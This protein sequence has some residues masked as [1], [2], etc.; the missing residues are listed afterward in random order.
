[1]LKILTIL[2]ARP[3]F[4]KAS[5]VSRV[6]AMHNDMQEILVHTGQHFDDNMSRVFFE[7]MQIPEPKYNLGIHSL[8]HGAM[9]GRM[10]EAAEKI[11]MEEKPDRVL[12]YGDTNST[13]AGALAAKKLGINIAHV[14]AGL[15]SFNMD[16]PEEVN[17]I[18]T[19]RISS[20]LFCPTIVAVNNLLDEGF[21][22]FSTEIIHSGD[23]MLDA[24]LYFARKSTPPQGIKLPSQFV[25]ATIHRAENTDNHEVFLSIAEAI[26]K[27]A[28]TVQVV[29]PMHP[30]T[31]A[32]L[33]NHMISF[34]GNVVIIPPVGYLEMIYLL[35]HCMAVITDSGGLQKEAY[36]FAK[37][38]VTTRNQ[39]EWTEL[40]EAGYNI[41]AGTR[42]DSIIKAFFEVT[43]RELV[44]T[45]GLY[46][47]GNA[48]EIIVENLRG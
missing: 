31:A 25:L 44:F 20:L 18:I 42:K 10:T 3:Q 48:A 28:Q 43:S 29:L 9:T 23:V 40:A 38:C 14:E 11:M 4:I 45:H 27:I 1:M 22:N 36:F 30:R 2:G 8:P 19:D 35:Q 34:S 26:T 15:R 33:K 24:S 6:M 16:M 47:E 12:V 5:A 7:Q 41:V 13:L 32:V 39:T 21:E 37:P 17:R 46:G